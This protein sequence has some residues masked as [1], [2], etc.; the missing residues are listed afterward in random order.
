M[1]LFEIIQTSEAVKVYLPLE[2]DVADTS[3]NR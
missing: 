2:D 3:N 1:T